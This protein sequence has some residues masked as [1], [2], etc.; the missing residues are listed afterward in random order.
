MLRKCWLRSPG[1]ET[2]KEVS[3]QWRWTNL[4]WS[5]A[6]VTFSSRN[7][8]ENELFK[9]TNPTVVLSS[10]YKQKFRNNSDVPWCP[11]HTHTHTHT[12]THKAGW[13]Y[14]QHYNFKQSLQKNKRKRSVSLRARRQMQ[15]S[16]VIFV[17]V[18]LHFGKWKCWSGDVS[19]CDNCVMADDLGFCSVIS[20]FCLCVRSISNIFWDSGQYHVCVC[21]FI[22][23]DILFP[24]LFQYD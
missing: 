6:V 1:V 4:G 16:I 20:C 24:L 10:V 19:S 13:G 12:H 15:S 14:K 9:Q 7:T 2:Q 5:L 11:V 8:R 17:V 3:L 21:L 22:G 23:F 18:D